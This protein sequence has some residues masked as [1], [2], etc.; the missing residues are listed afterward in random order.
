MIK[1][2]IEMFAPMNGLDPEIWR[3]INTG[4]NNCNDICIYNWVP[5]MYFIVNR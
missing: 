5:Y 4:C 2:T 1:Y 3:F